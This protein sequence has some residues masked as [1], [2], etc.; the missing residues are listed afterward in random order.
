MLDDHIRTATEADL[1]GM[2]ALW[3]AL[4]NVQGSYRLFPRVPDAE[5]RIE[6]LFREAMTDP[7][8]ALFVAEG[9]DGL[10]GMSVARVTGQGHHSMSDARVVELS[11]VVVDAGARG[12][13]IGRALVR[14]AARFGAAHGATFLTAKLFSGNVDGRQFW[15]RLGFV[16]RYEERIM[17]IEQ[18][19]D[20]DILHV[21]EILG[22]E[23][24]E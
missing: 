9:P 4:E 24:A 5:A 21:G 13:G 1:A 8:S 6:G 20:T 12:R 3:R 7:E 19:G 22:A 23:E 16:A 18:L 2:L 10:L 11:R 15:D 17:P 14:A